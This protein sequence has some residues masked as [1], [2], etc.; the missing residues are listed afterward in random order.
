MKKLDLIIIIGTLF[1]SLLSLFAINQ[2]KEEGD[3]VVIRVNG[4]IVQEIPL[5][6]DGTYPL[7]NGSNTL[8]IENGKAYLI[9]PTC[10]D[11]TCVEWGPIQFT[12]ETITCLPNSLTIIIEGK[13]IVIEI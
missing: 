5:T 4:N 3:I 8:V 7:N 12:G 6:Q 11:K 13:D 1:I 9:E 10:P 2:T